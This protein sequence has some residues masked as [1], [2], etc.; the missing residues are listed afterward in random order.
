MKQQEAPCPKSAGSGLQ[1]GLRGLQEW[2]RALLAAG[3]G[4]GET[5]SLPTTSSA[6]SA[7]SLLLNP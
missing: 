7:L 5:S 3:D 6:D 1:R 4:V 2:L